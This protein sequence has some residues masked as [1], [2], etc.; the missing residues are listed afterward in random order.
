M[1]AHPLRD[2]LTRHLYS[3]LPADAGFAM[4]S[5]ENWRWVMNREWFETLCE[6]FSVDK[7][8]PSEPPAY[9]LGF[10]VTVSPDGGVP[11]LESPAGPADQT[12]TR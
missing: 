12:R 11:R 6:A 2:D 4:W 10:P 3:Q 8:T 9:L 1:A 5:G 7:D